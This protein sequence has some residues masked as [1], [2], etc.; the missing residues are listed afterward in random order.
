MKNSKTI[1]IS[2]A[3]EYEPVEVRFEVCTVDAD[4]TLTKLL[5]IIEK[6]LRATGWGIDGH[7]RIVK[8]EPK[9]KGKKK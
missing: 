9:P 7:L 8:D 2:T 1:M 4:F 6:F 5:E 3:D